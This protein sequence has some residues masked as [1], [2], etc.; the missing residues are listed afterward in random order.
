MRLTRRPL[1]PHTSQSTCVPV[2][3]LSR[4]SS[5]LIEQYIAAHPHPQPDPPP[6]SPTP[7]QHHQQNGGPPH[8]GVDGPKPFGLVALSFGLV[9]AEGLSGDSDADALGDTSQSAALSASRAAFS[10]ALCS[11]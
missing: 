11:E 6:P 9:L 3:I 7:A 5:S 2:T 1:A 4:A 10:L 8:I